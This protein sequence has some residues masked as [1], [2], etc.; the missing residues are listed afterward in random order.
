MNFKSQGKAKKKKKKGKNRVAKK[1]KE[2]E[3]RPRIRVK[4]KVLRKR[5]F[6]LCPSSQIMHNKYKDIKKRRQ[7]CIMLN[8]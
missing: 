2:I 7:Y 6:I 1:R 4:F 3:E 8:N 5:I